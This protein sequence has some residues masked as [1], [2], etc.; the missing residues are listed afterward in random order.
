[1]NG[2]TAHTKEPALDA[3]EVSVRYGGVVAV[4]GVTLSIANGEVVTVLGPNGAGKSSLL[5]CISGAEPAY[6]G[7]VRIAGR[8]I[9]N[10]RPDQILHSGL[11]HVLEGRQ[12]FAGMTVE[13]NL[14]LGGTIRHDKRQLEDDIRRLYDTVPMLRDKRRVRA[15]F[16]SGGQQQMLAIGRALLSRPSVLLL[17]EPSL[18]I[19]PV[20]LE[21][22]A[23]LI[24]WVNEQLGVSILLVEQHT[25]LA[26]AVA[27]R[28]YVMVRGRVVREGIA[29]DFVD[30]SQLQQLYLGELPPSS[31]DTV[32]TPPGQPSS[33]ARTPPA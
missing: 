5:R 25:A 19:A 15:M 10:K 9:T 8:D 27:T 4:R 23:N 32:T 7:R 22:V 24:A 18:G 16:L 6:R 30:G 28:C 3:H 1:M 11:A 31:G 29:A 21:A 17:D 2:T 14:R 12:I 33:V 13:E 26:L 20:M